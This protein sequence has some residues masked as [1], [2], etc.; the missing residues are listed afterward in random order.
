MSDEYMRISKSISYGGPSLLP[1]RLPPSFYWTLQSDPSNNITS[2]SEP[3]TTNNASSYIVV[4]VHKPDVPRFVCNLFFNAPVNASQDGAGNN[5]PTYRTSW[6][7]PTYK[8]SCKY[9]THL[10]YCIAYKISLHKDDIL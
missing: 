1:P 9:F 2:Y 7:T 10:A 4:K 6:D 3:A 5:A 8:V